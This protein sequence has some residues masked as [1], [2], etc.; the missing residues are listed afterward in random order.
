MSSDRLSAVLSALSDPTRRAILAQ[1]AVKGDVPVKEL[2]KPFRISL[3]AVSRHLSVLENAGLISR[4]RDA[5]WRPAR[6]Q[7]EPLREVSDW[8]ERYRRFWEAR[9][10]RLDTYLQ[11]L[12]KKEKTNVRKRRSK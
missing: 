11:Q 8:V 10:V 2:A 3:P 9:F 7:A 12:Q 5:Q 1:L 4:G 6:L